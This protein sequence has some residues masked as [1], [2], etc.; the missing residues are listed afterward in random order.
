[1]YNIFLMYYNIVIYINRVPFDFLDTLSELIL[2]S[3]DL[4]M[5]YYNDKHIEKLKIVNY[6]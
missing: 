4:F 2:K 6:C 1:M 5:I 3:R